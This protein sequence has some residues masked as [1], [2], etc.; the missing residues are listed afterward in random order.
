[1]GFFRVSNLER[2][3]HDPILTALKKIGPFKY[4]RYLNDDIGFEF[5][6]E[7]HLQ[8]ALTQIDLLVLRCKI[9]AN[10]AIKKG[11]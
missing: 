3:M 2:G 11:M 5:E 9:H 10:M 8:E 7:D 4:V 6:E 1:M